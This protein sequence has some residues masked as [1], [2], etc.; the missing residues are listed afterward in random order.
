MIRDFSILLEPVNTSSNK[1]DI[2]MVSNYNA[3]AQYIE[4]VLKTQKNELVSNMNFGSDY[5]SFIFGQGDRPVLEL[6]LA[7]YI[8]SAIP[9]LTNIKVKLLSQSNTNLNFNVFFDFYDGIKMQK[10]LSCSIEVPI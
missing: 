5:Y 9:K 10:N 7:A 4:N 3:Y 8:Q 6:K 1:K 2:S